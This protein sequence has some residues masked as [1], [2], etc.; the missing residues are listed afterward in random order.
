[1][2]SQ[3]ISEVRRDALDDRVERIDGP[4]RSLQCILR[5]QIEDQQSLLRVVISAGGQ[6]L[7]TFGRHGFVNGGLRR[8]SSGDGWLGGDDDRLPAFQDDPLKPDVICEDAVLERKPVQI[9]RRRGTMREGTEGNAVALLFVGNG[10]L[11]IATGTLVKVNAMFAAACVLRGESVRLAC[12]SL[13][14]I[15]RAVAAPF[16]FALRARAQWH[17]DLEL[18]ERLHA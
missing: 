13:R 9:L 2:L 8:Q 1:M 10:R 18:L 6:L 5:K 16:Q 11:E 7:K 12:R 15:E 4:V 17:R 14:P 3:E